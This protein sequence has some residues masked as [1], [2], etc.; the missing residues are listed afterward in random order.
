MK[1]SKHIPGRNREIAPQPMRA[2]AGIEGAAGRLPATSAPGGVT[3]I[4]T[5]VA[6]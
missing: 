6:A 4:A 2:R 5:L 1:L 3:I